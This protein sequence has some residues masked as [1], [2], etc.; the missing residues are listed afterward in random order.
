MLRLF[1]RPCSKKWGCDR[2][3]GGVGNAASVEVKTSFKHRPAY[4]GYSWPWGYRFVLR[5]PEI[6]LVFAIDLVCCTLACWLHVGQS[7]LPHATSACLL[8]LTHLLDSV[9]VR[10]ISRQAAG[11]NK[12]H[13]IC[14][15]Q[16]SSANCVN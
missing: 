9:T 7:K 13:C 10:K 5:D 8:S 1:P 16:V 3:A 4:G 15:G 11:V 12:Y 6:P 14:A 2:V